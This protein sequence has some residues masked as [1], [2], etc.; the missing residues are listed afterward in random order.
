MKDLA[1]I[2]LIILL[3]SIIFPLG[4][5]TAWTKTR[6]KLICNGSSIGFCTKDEI[7]SATL[8]HLEI[9]KKNQKVISYDKNRIIIQWE[10][11]I[12]ANKE[13]WICDRER[14]T[15][16]SGND[17]IIYLSY[18][19]DPKDPRLLYITKSEYW[20]AKMQRRFIAD[21]YRLS[22]GF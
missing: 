18:P 16:H 12:I 15:L 9:D 3:A 4:E 1:P 10:D 5:K 6:Y 21:E 2:L 17:E 8:T 22:I 7:K 19:Y 20:L 13:N 14:E 11:C